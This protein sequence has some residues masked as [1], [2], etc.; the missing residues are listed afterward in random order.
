MKLSIRFSGLFTLVN[1]LKAND[2]ASRGDVLFPDARPFRSTAPKHPQVLPPHDPVLELPGAAIAWKSPLVSKMGRYTGSGSDLRWSLTGSVVS[3]VEA[4]ASTGTTTEL[5]GGVDYDRA[6][7]AGPE[8]KP[9]EE[10]N[11][12]WLVSLNALGPPKQLV[13]HA[14]LDQG[15][16][17]APVLCRVALQAGRLDAAGLFKD[18]S[19]AYIHFIAVNGNEATPTAFEQALA[20]GLLWWH[21]FASGGK[22]TPALLLEGEGKPVT[23]PLDGTATGILAN[24]WSEP[25]NSPPSKGR[26]D[27]LLATY[28]LAEPRLSDV[29]LLVPKE[30]ARSGLGSE[31]DFRSLGGTHCPPDQLP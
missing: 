8:P 11:L 28:L 3:V 26:A 15:S 23:I 29:D 31:I 4:D 25:P 21:E 2:P 5:S 12:K 20:S 6:A 18:E 30:K 10:G 1:K 14:G 27:H 16:V 9:G 17:K 7:P 24:I 22:T 19:G 13:L